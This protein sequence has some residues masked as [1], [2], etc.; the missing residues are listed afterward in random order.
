MVHVDFECPTQNLLQQL[1]L[2][3]FLYTEG[4]QRQA[5]QLFPL[6]LVTY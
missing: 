5:I 6:M 1:F 4:Y 3:G 2:G